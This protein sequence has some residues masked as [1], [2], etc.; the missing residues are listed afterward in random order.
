[1]PSRS[2][3]WERRTGIGEYQYAMLATPVNK[4]N[5]DPPTRG[6]KLSRSSAWAGLCTGGHENSLGQTVQSFASS[7]GIVA[8]PV[9]T[10][11]P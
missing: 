6:I 3:Q 7:R 1:M 5:S 9:I 8:I 2:E 4:R 10:W 11:V